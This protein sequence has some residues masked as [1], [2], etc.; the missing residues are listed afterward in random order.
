LCQVGRVEFERVRHLFT[1]EE[2]DVLV[3]SLL[4]GPA[5]DPSGGPGTAGTGSLS[6]PRRTEADVL[7]LSFAQERIWFL[8]QWEPDS[9]AYNI[10]IALRLTGSL[11]V[12]ALERSLNEI[13]RRHE[14]LR[15][16]CL[17]RDGR[18]V[19][20]RRSPSGSERRRLSGWRWRRPSDRSICRRRRS[21]G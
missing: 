5:G 19:P 8:S 3:H 17:I 1:L 9:P 18:P 2:T 20:C 13:V 10:P 16:R 11:N 4:G 15:T 14:I 12:A 6:I 7:P 21:C